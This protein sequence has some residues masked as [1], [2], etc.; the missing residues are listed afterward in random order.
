[1]Q[2]RLQMTL[3]DRLTKVEGCLYMTGMQALVRLPIQQ[4]M[5]D[6]AAG[7]NTGGFISGYRGSPIGR[8]DMELTQAASVLRAH[9]IH[10]Q[11]GVNEDLAATA[12]WGSQY[13]GT[14]PGAR[15]DGVF[16]IWYGKTPGLDRSMDVLKH[17]NLAG[18][19]RLGGSLLLV[20][21]D[22][23]AKSS[24]VACYSEMNFPALGVPMLAPSTVQ[25]VL[26]FG[27]HGIALSRFAGTLAAMKLVTDVI[28]GGG[29][30]DVGTDRP[31]VCLPAGG[32]PDMAA[33]VPFLEQERTLFE[34]RLALAQAYIRANDL[35]RVV[36]SPDGAAE[37]GLVAAGKTW[38]DL[39]Q[40]LRR[41]SVDDGRLGGRRIR[42]LKIGVPWPLD[43]EIVGRFAE[44]LAH[45]VVVEEKRG[46]IEDQVRA[47]L[48]GTS[49]PP[50]ITGK[51]YAAGPKAG[52]AAF[53]ASGELSP[54]LVADI[55][56]TLFNL[57]P[58]VN[59]PASS[60]SVPVRTPTFCAGCPHGR[61][62]QVISGSRAM[63]GIGCHSIAMLQSPR[64]TNAVSHMGG[65]GAMWI[66]QQPFTD[67]SHVFAN[68]GD[69]TYFHSGY[70]AIRAAVA[71]KVPIT[72]KLL[73]NGFVSMT[74]GQ[75]IDGEMSVARAVA[76]LRAEGVG[77]I[78]IVAD[79]PQRHRDESLPEG[80]SLHARTELGAVQAQLRSYKGVSVLIYDQ[81]CATERRRLRKR[82]KWPDP[83]IRVF[84]DPDVCEGCGDCSTVSG[85]MAIEP[86]DTPLGRKRQINQSSCNKDFSCVEGF[87]PSLITIEGAKPRKASVAVSDPLAGIDLP[88]PRLPSAERGFAVLVAGV[89]GTGVVTIGQSLAVAAHADGLFASNLD[90]TGLA[91]KYG[92][93]MSHVKIA[94]TS[95]DLG[96]SRIDAGE[97]CALIGADL[98]V[99]ASS[100]VLNSIRQGQTV[101]VI[102]ASLM[103]TAEFS[104]SPDWSADTGELARRIAART[105]G[106][107]TVAQLTQLAEF[108]LGD[109]VFANQMCL[110][111]V[112]QA[113][114]IPV[115]LTAMMRAIELNGVAIQA[116]KR[117]F[118]LG[119][120][121]IVAPERMIPELQVPAVV[122]LE[123]L[124][125]DRKARLVEYG[126]AAL[127]NRY[128]ALVK[129]V[130]AADQGSDQP[131]ARAVATYYYKL[132]AHKDEW[133][134][135]RLYARPEFRHRLAD[136]F[137]GNLK[138]HFHLAGGPFARLAA[139]GDRPAKVRVGSWVLPVFRFVSAMRG[140]RGTVLDPFRRSPES[141]LAKSL[142]ADY[143][144]DVELVLACGGS[145]PVDLGQELL[146]FPEIVRGYGHVREKHAFAMRER[147]AETLA[148]VQ[149]ARA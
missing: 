133:E 92:A 97:A 17:A 113:G 46:F 129:R 109:A 43:A 36:E 132:L 16:S 96:P 79:E 121:L 84:I 70:L 144:T 77:R 80:V 86:L 19:S 20:G 61:S 65:E 142:L 10:F 89:G 71:A 3:E 103:P 117:A 22:P 81:A 57:E 11:P 60:V 110:G 55:L 99:S 125:A 123:Q 41:L 54:S 25:E 40:A 50:L 27:L 35:N 75:P 8:Y 68:M 34:Q 108:H 31:T 12:A 14:Y 28:E 37:I 141:V 122:G 137:E 47:I 2:R 149:A 33:F 73:F 146:S 105:G 94:A 42:L 88:E 58:P 85:C 102:N 5:R 104:R 124:V 111:A 128:A 114:G 23:G 32:R 24:T 91:Q 115:S 74:G 26:D 18:T 6:A 90:V 118:A 112:W 136:A 126:G 101:A 48:Y 135:A 67:E 1:M 138:F 15:V 30:V 78:A 147:R 139:K 107:T 145:L 38:T 4:R 116:N 62:T 51:R 53:P 83:D 143:E 76:Q 119:R 120:L 106:R 56:A 95:D 52:L 49:S 7:L 9:N 93:V 100:E 59:S 72:Y 140:L 44:G 21:D 131:W 87:C 82:G 45:I 66:G 63:A 29:S 98:I 127:A 13:V 134:V 64:T 130:A 69:G 148:R 39:E